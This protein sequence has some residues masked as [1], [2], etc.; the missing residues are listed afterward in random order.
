MPVLD[1]RAGGGLSSNEAR[2]KT[3]R[4]FRW[5]CVTLNARRVAGHS[6]APARSQHRIL[7][8]MTTDYTTPNAVLRD[9]HNE[10]RER[11]APPQLQQSAAPLHREKP[12]QD[13]PHAQPAASAP[14][15]RSHAQR[16]HAQRLQDGKGPARVGG[17]G[18]AR[19]GGASGANDGGPAHA[20]SSDFLRHKQLAIKAYRSSYDRCA[21]EHFSALQEQRAV[22]PPAARACPHMRRCPP[23]DSCR[24][25][26]TWELR[27]GGGMAP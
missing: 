22:V 25:G 6:T 17:K 14:R 27:V 23:A 24:A 3:L 11:A 4:D 21:D 7:A 19:V 15:V 18:P 8:L 20:I 26:A 10:R 5:A 16:L 12:Q 1:L 9:L 13:K 2:H